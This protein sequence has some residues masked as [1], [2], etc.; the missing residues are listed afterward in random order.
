M[1]LR[2][3]IAKF[4]NASNISLLEVE[5]AWSKRFKTWKIPFRDQKII[6]L[7]CSK[8]KLSQKKEILTYINNINKEKCLSIL[9][10]FVASLKRDRQSLA[11]ASKA[12]RFRFSEPKILDDY[13]TLVFLS[14]NYN[15][16]I[17]KDRPRNRK[18]NVLISQIFS[19]LLGKWTNMLEKMP[20]DSLR[21][22]L[23]NSSDI[24]PPISASNLGSENVMNLCM[25]LKIG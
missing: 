5:V 25:K 19:L 11:G 24:T 12:Q 1:F 18:V 17:K 20:R 2:R 23:S 14:V 3:V 15:I 21:W 10:T 13:V 6:L 4:V 9:S 16:P 8:Q 22:T 7:I